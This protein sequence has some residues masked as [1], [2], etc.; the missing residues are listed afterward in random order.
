M[1]GQLPAKIIAD[2]KQNVQP[3]LNAGNNFSV[4]IE[5]L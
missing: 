2:K 3:H 4:T 5:V 1:P